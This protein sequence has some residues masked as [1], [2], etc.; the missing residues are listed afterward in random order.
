LR[1]GSLRE[2]ASRGTWIGGDSGRVGV[3]VLKLKDTFIGLGFLAT[4]VAA[5]FS[6]WQALISGDTERRSLRAYVGLVDPTNNPP[7]GD[8]LRIRVTVM[9]Y[10][11]TPAKNVEF[12]G[13]WEFVQPDVIHLPDDF[14]FPDKPYCPPERLYGGQTIFPKN[15]L[16]SQRLHCPEEIAKLLQAGTWNAVFYGHIDYQDI[17]N[18]KWKTTYC[19]LYTNGA[20][21]LCDRHNEIDAEE[22]AIPNNHLDWRMW[23]KARPAG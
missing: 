19:I 14:T 11:A 5:G 9:N 7:K 18:K 6:G 16:E 15:T 22:S 1:P 3:M 12:Y 10:G 21:I 17:F 20:P 8:S 23:F 2:I 13:N 4:A